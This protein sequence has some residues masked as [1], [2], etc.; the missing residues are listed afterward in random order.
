MFY[1]CESVSVNPYCPTGQFITSGSLKFGRWD[2]TICPGPGVN[3]ST[4]I[5]FGVFTLP[6][7]C[8]QG[9]NSC[10]LGNSKS[11]VSIFG[12]PY[13]GVFKHVCMLNLFIEDLITKSNL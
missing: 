13:P 2:N 9:V 7:F 3:V 10:N 8:L 4:P 1:S 5:S 11:L 6:F 12:D